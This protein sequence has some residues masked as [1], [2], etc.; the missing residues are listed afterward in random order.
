[1]Y[2]EGF[3]WL[4]ASLLPST[5]VQ[6]EP[7]CTNPGAEQLQGEAPPPL[8]C[9]FLPAVFCR[10][11]RAAD[12]TNPAVHRVMLYSG[13]SFP[14]SSRQISQGDR[15]GGCSLAWLCCAVSHRMEQ[16]L[17]SCLPAG[18]L[19]LCHLPSL[20]HTLHVPAISH[21]KQRSSWNREENLPMAYS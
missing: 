8:R 2:S 19:Q 13:G 15:R 11:H 18:W 1:M 3:L 14:E 17:H 10:R 16:R 12:L 5:M 7:P 6:A 9:P 21:K 20:L 4:S